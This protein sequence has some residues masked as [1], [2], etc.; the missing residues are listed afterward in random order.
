MDCYKDEVARLERDYGEMTLGEM[1]D[2]L[3]IVIYDNEGV[4]FGYP[5]MG[6]L[7][8][9]EEEAKKIFDTSEI[10]ELLKV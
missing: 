4:G 5:G 8:E 2:A 9:N 6:K 10:R 1:E 7:P 3:G